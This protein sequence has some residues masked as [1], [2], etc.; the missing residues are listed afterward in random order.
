MC[1][2]NGRKFICNRRTFKEKKRSY[3]CFLKKDE[4]RHGQEQKIG[5]NP[6]VNGRGARTAASGFE[7]W[8]LA[9][10]SISSGYDPRDWIPRIFCRECPEA[11]THLT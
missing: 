8:T 7:G 3:F 5:I 1:I 9:L 4:I 6:T 2:Y 10:S 11:E